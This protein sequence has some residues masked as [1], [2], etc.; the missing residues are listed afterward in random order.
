MKTLL[1]AFLWSV[2][3][4]AGLIVLAFGGYVG[5]GFLPYLALAFHFP[6]MCL[7]QRWPSVQYGY[8]APILVQWVIWFICFATGLSVS[9][10]IRRR[11]LEHGQPSP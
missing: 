10:L 2:C 5:L 7:L 6:A 3:F 9:K 8:V 11:H 4:E 1:K